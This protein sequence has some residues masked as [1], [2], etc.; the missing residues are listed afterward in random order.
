MPKLLYIKVSP[1][2]ESVSA[3]VAEV[4]LEEL[5][6]DQSGWEIETLSLFATNLPSF[7][8]P[9]AKAKYA[10]LSGAEPIGPEAKIWREVIDVIEHFKS[11]DAYV[12]ACPMWNFG[13]P[14][15]LKHYIDILVQPALT[16]NYSPEAGY[17][18]LVT[19]RPVLLSL[20]RGGDYSQPEAQSLDMQKPYLETI[21]NFIGLTD[22]RT[23]I[24]Q[25][26]LIGGPKIMDSAL[27]EA[28]NQAKDLAHHWPTPQPA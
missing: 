12:I 28:I 1:R 6:N 27:Q 14:Y 26:T 18:G 15:K 3:K 17:S 8:A 16:F 23:I 4:F 5:R 9:A 11:A 2:V 20:A 10:V 24:T 7:D 13:I 25:P 19:G 22:I 21:L